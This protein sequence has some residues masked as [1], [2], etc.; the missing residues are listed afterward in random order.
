M[1]GSPVMKNKHHKRRTRNCTHCGT[2]FA[3]NPRLGKRHRYCSK[4]ECA[5]ASRRASIKRWLKRN[6]GRRYFL[7][8][9]ATDRVRE[10]RQEHPRYWQRAG[11]KKS[12]ASGRLVVTKELAATLRYVALQNSIDPHLALGIGMISQITGVAL[13]NSIAVEIRR[14]ML[15]GYAI[16]R[17]QSVRPFK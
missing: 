2:S 8:Q 9:H 14:L 4:S 10:W 6:G 12:H 13:Q 3:V 1:A 17:G 11:R 5:K 7:G 16:L 15:R